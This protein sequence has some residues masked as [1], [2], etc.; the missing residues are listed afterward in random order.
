MI[1]QKVFDQVDLNPVLEE[2]LEIT[3][4]ETYL[5]ANARTGNYEYINVRITR[6]SGL[7][8]SPQDIERT[9]LS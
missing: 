7:T 8:Y 1:I 9:L 4:N 6:E 3:P 2:M 5:L